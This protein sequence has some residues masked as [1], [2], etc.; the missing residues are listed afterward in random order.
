MLVV[1]ARNDG[2]RDGGLP[3]LLL[4]VRNDEAKRT[5]AHDDGGKNMQTLND[6]MDII[7]LVGYAI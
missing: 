5:C 6:E 1:Q 2:T 7:T 4:Q 3:Y